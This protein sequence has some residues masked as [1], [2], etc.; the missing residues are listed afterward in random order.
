[1]NGMVAGMTY[2]LTACPTSRWTRTSATTHQH[3]A[4]RFQNRAST[5]FSR[6][7]LDGIKV[8]VAVHAP[9][10]PA[11]QTQRDALRLKCKRL[12]EVPQPKRIDRREESR[13]DG[14]QRRP[15][16]AGQVAQ[17]LEQLKVLF[18]RRTRVGRVGAHS[19]VVDVSRG[20]GADGYDEARETW[21]APLLR[22]GVVGEE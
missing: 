5:H 21:F 9:V 4:G 15:I 10:Q 8:V 19:R 7:L 17:S 22:V 14:V 12:A 6:F 13:L 18:S 11:V 1:M 16:R 3:S 20:E 2:R